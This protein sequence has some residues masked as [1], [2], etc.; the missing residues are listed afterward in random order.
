[1]RKGFWFK[2][3]AII[4]AN[5]L[6]SQIL[7]PT[8]A[9][10]LTSGPGSPEFSSFEP[11]ATTDMVNVFSGDFT[12]NL[13]VVEIPGSEGG[14]YALSL[15]YHSGTSS[16]EEASWVGHGWTLNPGSINRG[17]RG[18][19]DDYNGTNV[20]QYNKTRPNW[21]LSATH[22]LN[23]E[24]FSKEERNK[25]AAD[26]S[27]TPQASTVSFGI[28]MALRY[29]NYQ[30]FSRSYNFGPSFKGF[31]SLDMNISSSGITFSADVNPLSILNKLRKKDKGKSKAE[32]FKDEMK[33]LDK[34]KLSFKKMVSNAG[35]AG[36]EKAANTLGNSGG[37]SAFGLFVF[38]QETSNVSVAVNKG[39]NLNY[40]LSLMGTPSQT[41]VGIN[42][43][44]SGSF[45]MQ[46]NIPEA[47]LNGYGYRY[48]PTSGGDDQMS[49]YFV[50]KAQPFDKRDLFMG[51][52]FSNADMFSLT[53]EGLSGGFRLHQQKTGVF[54]PTFNESKLKIYNLGFQLTL[55]LDLG[56]GLTFGFGIQ[57]SKIRDWKKPGNVNDYQFNGSEPLLAFN[58]DLGSKIEYGNNAVKAVDVDKKPKFPG[59]AA[60][61][62]NIQ[63]AVIA[64]S[65]KPDEN[66]AYYNEAL[67]G[68]SSFLKSH[69]NN[70]G[71][72][73]FEILNAD[74]QRYHYGNYNSILNGGNL[75]GNYTVHARKEA[76]VSV[77][78]I[79]EP[80]YNNGEYVTTS[81]QLHLIDNTSEYTVEHCEH[82]VVMGEIKNTAYANTY[83][84]RE[85]TTPE[86]VD[87]LAPEGASDGDFG[88][89]T[90]FDYWKDYGTNNDN[91]NSMWYRWRAPY[92]GLLYQKNSISD[93]TDD[94][95]SVSTGEREVYYLKKIET[96]THIAYF[97]T[98][99]SNP[100]RFGVGS[101]DPI[102]S[103]LQGSGDVRN[104]GYGAKQIPGS[105][106]DPASSV[107][108][109]SQGTEKM[110]RLEK[111][112]LIAKANPDKPMKIVHFQYEYSLVPNLP[113]N[114]YG[115]FPQQ[116]TSQADLAKSGKLTLVKVWAEYEGV[117]GAKISPYEFT[118]K[119]KNY[120]SF[121]PELITRYPQLNSFFNLSNLYSDA[122]QNPEYKP[123]LLDGWGY[124]QARGEEQFK[125]MRTGLYQGNILPQDQFDP[126]AWQLKQ[127]KLPSGGQIMVEY[128]QKDYRYVQDRLA[129]TLVSLK[130]GE[131]GPTNKFPHFDLNLDDLGIDPA[132]YDDYVTQLNSYYNE[133]NRHMFFKFLYALKDN[134]PNLN[135]CRSEYIDGYCKV[136]LD[137]GGPAEYIIG[138]PGIVRIHL[139]G[140]GSLY[141]D[142]NMTPRQ[143]CYDFYSTNRVGKYNFGC[144]S[145]LDDR[146]DRTVTD[147]AR[148][149]MCE[150]LWTT[151]I[152]QVIRKFLFATAAIVDM[153][154]K[155]VMDLSIQPPLK[156]SVC[157][158]VNW[159]LSYL[160]VPVF[161][162]KR[163]GGVRVKTLLMLDP[164]IE[165]GDAVVY[166]SKYDY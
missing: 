104:D 134:N 5:A 47:N 63:S 51:V 57:K 54:Y 33:T 68:R 117:V 95:A 163:G 2:F 86:Y 14:G 15:S 48:S 115:K 110:E 66:I 76:S 166:G 141:G 18:L 94:L 148:D 138:N 26:P 73:G 36:L 41:P 126:A 162:N 131:N 77:D 145:D 96:K 160:K 25:N 165:T 155:S 13:P 120:T 35:K 123:Y 42:Y 97:V 32:T 91:G 87:D 159:E 31:G 56:V 43:G 20:K 153:E 34:K 44:T 140:E 65:L 112:I 19:P 147:I 37:G 30:G 53:G 67:I 23:F 101:G 58:S 128:E 82:D 130:T 111:V 27:H 7:F 125:K 152:K 129:T 151:N 109:S 135:S 61:Q 102:A 85:I 88:G 158:S 46:Y 118:Y 45:S 105:S 78:A 108:Y 62:P 69:N 40:S 136:R 114:F 132:D 6:L 4:V 100:A 122:A 154:V 116:P 119:Y 17:V 55:G 22:K 150:N 83:L 84:I 89:W 121:A 59:V 139:D 72:E 11:V 144:E 142:Y 161:K 71:M 29:N 133:G 99:E 143:G 164:G 70:S 113:N 106:I 64:T 52:P 75:E 157:T 60:A 137:N 156:Q 127:I 10:A 50:E 3:T 16:E 92:T 24:S 90:K 38:H 28:G 98:N 21:S 49:D 80:T 81:K 107:D 8:I 124:N 79:N 74:G 146:Y 39:Y 1:M 149:D 103:Y 93:E 9:Y 12:Y